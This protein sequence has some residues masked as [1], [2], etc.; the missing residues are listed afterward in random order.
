MLESSSEAPTPLDSVSDTPPP[1]SPESKTAAPSR[2]IVDVW[3]RTEPRYR[4]R[5]VAM[6]VLNMLLFCG[7]CIFTHWLHV[8]EPFTFSW[9]S[10]A[11]PGRFWDDQTPN[12]NDFI[13][14]PISVEQTPIHGVVLGLLV[15][16]IVAIPIVISILYRFG[17]ALP[18][19]AA[20]LIFA[21]MP[22]M[23]AT[24]VL[25]CALA[26]LRP[27]RMSFRFGSALVGLL[28][29]ILYLYLATR[30]DADE[31]GAVAS[32]TQKTLL[33]APWVLALLAASAM[34]ATI[35]LIARLVNY[36]PGAV[37]PVVAVMFATPVALFH[38]YVGVDELHYRVLEHEYGPDSKRFAPVED[39]SDRIFSLLHEWT[40]ENFPDPLRRGELIAAWG[41]ELD[42]VKRLIARRMLLEFMNEREAAREAL[43]A[44]LADHLHSRYVPNVL[45][46]LART[47]DLRLDERKLLQSPPRRE[48]YTDFP[49]VQST[50]Y[51]STLLSRHGNSPLATAAALRL[52]LLSWRG[53]DCDAALAFLDQ[54][55]ALPAPSAQ[56]SRPAAVGLLR[57]EPPEVSLRYQPEPDRLE[58]ARL[59]ELILANRNDP[60]YGDAPLIAFA[61]LDWHRTRHLEEVLRLAQR[62]PDSLL[63]DD[64][65]VAWAAALPDA[66]QRLERLEDCVEHF[67]D[68]SAAPQ[69][70]F[71]LA[72]LE[73]LTAPQ[74]DGA[75]RS[76]G[77]ARMR[78]VATRFADSYWGRAAA[79]RLGM[80][81]ERATLAAREESRP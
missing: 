36:R 18:F 19:I 60:R 69:A 50:E 66:A 15:A 12:L 32:P 49:H 59:R 35:L 46:L 26:S 20:V 64:L 52:A 62:Y 78:E 45:F 77:I 21:H 70:M 74:G 24:L 9:D 56:A 65:I 40:Q 55:L 67:A 4:I 71:L 16:S 58:A 48:L 47:L 79:R 42:S 72:D 75:R 6:L 73:V 44:F 27:F 53:G 8:G 11:A 33:A 57:R 76:A 54:V 7:L 63:Y 31:L 3:S 25:C 2:Q 29:V 5:A 51:W 34:M 38:A 28:P 30:G 41:G 80:L 39:A 43:Q 61:A 37:A 14:F 81:D 22:W 1:P 13:L 17:Y 23:A 10:Y 68:G